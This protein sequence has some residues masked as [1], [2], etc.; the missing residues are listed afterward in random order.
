M[1]RA[2]K[3]SAG[4]IDIDGGASRVTGPVTSLTQLIFRASFKL[5]S[6][7]LSQHIDTKREYCISFDMSS[8]L[9]KYVCDSLDS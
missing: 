8:E 7:H 6:I 1:A 9:N 5:D 3:F 2:S 4:W